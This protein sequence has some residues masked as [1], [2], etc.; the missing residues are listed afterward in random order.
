MKPNKQDIKKLGIHLLLIAILTLL[1]EIL[2]FN[3][4]SFSTKS[5]ETYTPDLADV[6]SDDATQ[7]DTD[8]T[9]SISSEAIHFKGDG[10]VYLT[11]P[12]QNLSVMEITYQST[13]ND[14]ISSLE[15]KDGNFSQTF[16]QVDE[17]R[18]MYGNISKKE[19]TIQYSFLPYNHCSEVKLLLSDLDTGEVTISNITF[20]TTAPFSF[21]FARFIFCFLFLAA[22]DMIRYFK[23]HHIVYHPQSK[24]QG[25]FLLITILFMTGSVIHYFA[26]PNQDM[27]TYSKEA[28]TNG[29]PY[30]QMFD[31]IH[32]KRTS[33]AIEADEKLATLNN[34]YDY[35]EREKAQVSS[36]WD[37]AY[38]NGK[39]YSYF[40]IAPVLLYYYPA[41]LITGKLPTLNMACVFFST[42]SVIFFCFMILRFVKLFIP[43][44]NFLLLWISMITGVFTSGIYLAVNYSNMYTLA[45]IT[46]NCFVF[47]SIW[48]GLL[49]YQ[50]TTQKRQLPALCL[51]GISF[52]V[53][54]AARPTRALS[55]LVLAPVFIHILCKKDYSAKKKTACAASFLIPVFFGAIALMCYNNARFGSPFDFGQAYQLTVSDVHANTL[56]LRLLP[57]AIIKYFFQ[58]LE[59]ASHFPYFTYASSPMR[60]AGRY[61]YYAYN[62]GALTLPSIA[63][64]LLV[65]PF[66]CNRKR[67]QNLANEQQALQR[68]K[69]AVY[70]FLFAFAVITAWMDFC[71]GGSIMNYV[72]DILPA[73]SILAVLVILDGYQMLT[74]HSTVAN[75]GLIALC[76]ILIITM[77]IAA[78]ELF[79]MPAGADFTIYHTHPDILSDLERLLVFWK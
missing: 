10:S 3:S 43:K 79:V 48:L 46:A 15:M 65:L 16:K 45:G 52:V 37:R 57:F 13:D 39:Y 62:A 47:A 76:T 12:E 24:K 5:Y 55:S 73:L 66:V 68:I 4:K 74:S 23:L 69:H 42:L 59:L 34:P 11:L 28:V 8:S 71:I 14:V 1:A 31:A 9:V 19:R 21:S 6:Q 22:V 51:S 27:I 18:L 32:N 41:Y 38:Y 29:D 54:V 36:R 72:L 58:P 35:S 53:S 75:R 63:V 25:I 70:I 30:I 61:V 2:I 60:S 67:R 50:Q 64:S 77:G 7:S 44:A 40:G 49:G 56:S 20:Y 17:K 26:I 78:M 33:L